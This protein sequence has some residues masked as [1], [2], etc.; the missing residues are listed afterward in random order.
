MIST[1]PTPVN[2]SQEPVVIR[3]VQ[4]EETDGMLDLMCRSFSLDPDNAKRIFYSDPFFRLD[5]KRVLV[6][7]QSGA[8]ISCLTLVPTVLRINPI[9]TLSICGIAGV[10]TQ[11]EM[12]RRG[13]ARRLIQQALL[14]IPG[15]LGY[16]ITALTADRPEYYEQLGW[17]ACGVALDWSAKANSLPPYEER[18][19]VRELAADEMPSQADVIHKLYAQAR[20]NVEAGAFVR[21]RRR[22]RC[23]DKLSIGRRVAIC[24]RDGNVVAYGAYEVRAVEGGKLCYIRE[25]LARD[26]VA[27]R[28][29][30]G[31]FASGRLGDTVAGRCSHSDA[32]TLGLLSI[33]GVSIQTRPNIF[34]R[35][36]HVTGLL[37]RI[38]EHVPAPAELA[39]FPNG[40]AIRVKVDHGGRA[41]AADADGRDSGVVRA[42]GRKL[43][44]IPH[45]DDDGAEHW[46]EG[47]PGAVTQLLIGFKTSS[48]LVSEGR[49]KISNH[50]NG[51]RP[52]CDA[53]FPRLQPFLGIPDIF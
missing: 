3:A 11:P 33:P 53:L 18:S 17:A 6:G 22:W 41:H 7:A 45:T 32:V 31:Y 39:K 8:L 25:I 28:A 40:L 21:D 14:E 35:L 30:L 23:I 15:E 26:A 16:D 38:L 1:K 20:G 49:L 52:A 5:M 29:M 4:R 47:D 36:T 51:I 50:G 43:Q 2:T 10:C 12:Q 34:M 46:I 27:R 9:E 24:E 13:F 42:S 19:Q 37:R 48:E 44:I